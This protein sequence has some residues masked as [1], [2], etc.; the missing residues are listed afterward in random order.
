MADQQSITFPP[1]ALDPS[2]VDAF[3]G[4]LRGQL[5]RPGDGDSEAARPVW[6]AMID[7]H[8]ALSP[9]VPGRPM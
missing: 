1:H 4:R 5:L 6:N 2:A 7:R 3:A 9:D 8:Q